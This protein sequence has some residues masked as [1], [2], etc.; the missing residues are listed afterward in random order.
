M[1]KFVYSLFLFI[2]MSCNSFLDVDLNK[3]QI[4]TE[5]IFSNDVTATAAVTAMYNSVSLN[6]PLSG[7]FYG[8]NALSGLSSGELSN[9]S[10]D[11]ELK[12]FEQH[13]IS[14]KN[15]NILQLW[16]F[17]YNLIYQANAIVEGVDNSN[18]LSEATKQQLQGEALFMRAFTYFYLVN[19]FGEVPLITKTDYRINQS[20]SRN[21]VDDVYRLIESDL[22]TAQ[23]QLAK[24]YV[25][26]QRVR[27]N[28]ATATAL[29]AR[30]YLY[31]Q[32]YSK[33]ELQA[34][35]I[36]DDP[37]Y[38]LRAKNDIDK[39]FLIDSHETIWQ[40]MPV[41]STTNTVEGANFI[42]STTPRYHILT[43]DL[44]EHFTADDL[45]YPNWV[46]SYSNNAGVFYFPYKY[47]Q[48]SKDPA[49]AY[50]ECSI[51]FRLAEIYLVRAEARAHLNNVEGAQSDLNSIRS[52]AGLPNTEASD[53]SGLF[54][55]IESERWSELFTEYGHRWLDLKRT[56]RAMDVLGNGVTMDVLLYP[57][58]ADEFIKNPYLGTQ[59]HGY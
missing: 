51:V 4:N 28:K 20:L 55:A 2:S 14:P 47:K 18:G 43:D 12:A 32:D 40:I 1:K 8:M 41:F 7:I 30:M 49:A 57:I 15:S 23:S 52:R 50:T 21:A 59:N 34:S 48:N 31:R 27:P 37:A 19:L 5:E 36:I 42:I 58:P 53:P 11:L 29:L 39:V 3:S 9:Y 46:K 38:Q 13:V 35:A 54:L 16:N 24:T 22:L 25:T 45:R 10:Q 44:R 17:M 56:N 26:D 33:A 6:S